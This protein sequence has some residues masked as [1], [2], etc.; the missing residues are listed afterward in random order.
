MQNRWS[1]K[2]LLRILIVATI[3]PTVLLCV[4]IFLGGA[5]TY[6]EYRTTSNEIKGVKA[7][8]YLFHI[9]TDLQKIRGLH[10]INS[11]QHS[12]TVD[13]QLKSNLLHITNDFNDKNWSD[14]MIYFDIK[15]DVERIMTAEKQLSYYW[16][17]DNNSDTL[18]VSYTDL[19]KNTHQLIFLVLN[20]S[21]LILDPKLDTYYLMDVAINHV[22]EIVE[23]IAILRGYGGSLLAKGIV[24]KEDRYEFERKVAVAKNIIYKI[25]RSEMIIDNTSPDLVKSLDA[26]IN[27]FK[28]LV[29]P[30]LNECVNYP[31]KL[32]S[33]MTAESYFNKVSKILS[34]FASA[35]NIS[36][37]LLLIKLQN[38]LYKYY[39]YMV[40]TAIITLCAV[41]AILLTTSFC[42]RQQKNIYRTLE[43]VAVTDSL[44]DIPNRRLLDPEFTHQVQQAMREGKGMAFGLM[45]IDNFKL[46]NDTYGHNEG[47]VVLRKVA[48]SMKSILQRGSDYLFRYGGEEFCFFFYAD[49]QEEVEKIVNHI[50]RSIEDMAIEHINNLPYGMVTAS[51]GAVFYP[52]IENTD[53]DLWIKNADKMLY[54]AKDN[55]RNRCE[56]MT[57]SRH[58]D[59]D[60]R[61]LVKA[62]G[63]DF[64]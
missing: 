5:N 53:L 15:D 34:G 29:L 24:T 46:Y 27:A 7:I 43:K 16:D 6:Q 30:L 11:L 26:E 48:D 20:T 28:S 13:Q 64:L 8:Q 42:Y 12:D 60:G 35:F 25:N 55:G 52:N 61:F 1:Q 57:V 47:D 33:S 18:F 38:R 32:T 51:I 3:V 63:N 49:S 44:T 36:T 22:P 39:L 56:F 4:S 14:L 50:C 59:K 54:L 21:H 45:D 23:S 9:M 40:F 41:I 17:Y 31:C 19:I 10:Y 2:S 58:Y 62:G 37:D